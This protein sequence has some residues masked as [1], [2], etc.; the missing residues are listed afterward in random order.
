MPNSCVNEQQALGLV[1]SVQLV[2]TLSAKERQLLGARRL[3]AALRSTGPFQARLA[4]EYSEQRFR[5]D[6]AQGHTRIGARARPR[7]W[8][9][10]RRTRSRVGLY[11]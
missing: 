7:S 11:C 10:W 9:P 6:R 2:N 1:S 5:P 4:R 3:L 8:E